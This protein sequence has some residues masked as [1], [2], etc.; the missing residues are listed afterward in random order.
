MHG[1]SCVRLLALASFISVT[2]ALPGQ[3][4]P[5]AGRDAAGQSSPPN[6][7]AYSIPYPAPVPD[8]ALHV[9]PPSPVIPHSSPHLAP[10][11]FDFPQLARAAG[12]IFSGTVTGIVKHPATGAQT[13]ETVTI[14][15]HVENA[16]RGTVPGADVTISQWIGTW[17]NEQRYR[18][19]ERLLLFLYP[20]SRLGLTS[21]VGGQLGRFLVDPMHRVTLSPQHLL[22]FRADPI[23][24][25][26]S[27]AP[28]SDFARAVGRAEEK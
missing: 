17:S 10:Q 5:N 13:V 23:L 6:V 22:A 24:G 28:L 20:Q 11:T 2:T 18:V 27:R 16:I 21:C 26:K 19:G 3:H 4:P 12:L 1:R 7:P 8:P 25:G 9:P 14:S 15:F